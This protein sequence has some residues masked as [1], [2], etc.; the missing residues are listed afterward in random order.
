MNRRQTV[1]RRLPQTKY[2]LAVFAGVIAVVVVFEAIAV[3]NGYTAPAL[4]GWRLAGVVA[5][6]TGA[7]WA[8][9]WLT[10][11]FIEAAKGGDN[12]AE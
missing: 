12:G 1:P 8:L 3:D 7:A 4:T 2:L 9:D 10:N 6:A 5:F 11:C